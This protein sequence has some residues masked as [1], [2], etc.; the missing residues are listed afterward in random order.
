VL[1]AYKQ[2]MAMPTLPL[3][4][5]TERAYLMSEATCEGVFYSI[6]KDDRLAVVVPCHRVMNKNGELDGYGGG[7][8]RKRAL[9][10]LEQ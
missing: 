10:E 3:R 4:K 7:I 6:W 8:W 2:E 1:L 5:D 9:L